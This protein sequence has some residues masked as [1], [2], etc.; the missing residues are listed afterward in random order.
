[1]NHDHDRRRYPNLRLEGQLG[2]FA[3]QTLALHRLY[4]TWHTGDLFVPASQR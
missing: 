4:N 3:R 2:H 1:M